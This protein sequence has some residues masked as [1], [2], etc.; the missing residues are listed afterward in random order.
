VAP[1]Y[2]STPSVDRWWQGAYE[3]EAHGHIAV[4]YEFEFN[5]EVIRPK[6][7]IKMKNMRGKFKFRCIATNVR[8]GS[9]WIDCVDCESGEWRSFRVEKL[10]CI[11]KPKK[12][13]R[14]KKN[15]TV[16]SS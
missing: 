8:T 9:S 3:C 4:S 15:E 12:S 5:G 13:R 11:V 14:K 7:E 16:Q 6:T 1:K 2:S 10:K